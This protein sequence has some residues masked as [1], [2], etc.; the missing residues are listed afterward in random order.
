MM[1]HKHKRTSFFTGG[2]QNV[3]I[4]F[5]IKVMSLYL[6]IPQNIN[7]MSNCNA[8]S[9]A[10]CVDLSNTTSSRPLDL[11][12]VDGLGLWIAYFS[13]PGMEPLFTRMHN[14]WSSVFI[15]LPLTLTMDLSDDL[16]LETRHFFCTVDVISTSDEPFAI[17]RQSSAKRQSQ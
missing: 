9:K 16:G 11:Y 17:Q 13:P 5:I 15:D 4:L 14:W 1:L 2:L 8:D 12:L 6:K 10:M 7:S 3:V